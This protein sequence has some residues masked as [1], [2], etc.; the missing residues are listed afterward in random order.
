[1]NNGRYS[2]INH[3]KKVNTININ[4]NE[5]K[6]ILDEKNKKKYLEKINNNNNDK[7]LY[8]ERRTINPNDDIYKSEVYND[9]EN[10]NRIKEKVFNKDYIRKNNE[11]KK[12]TKNSNQLNKNVIIKNNNIN[13]S[14]NVNNFNKRILK[15]NMKGKTLNSNNIKKTNISTSYYI[16]GQ[17]NTTD[18]RYLPNNY[19]NYNERNNNNNKVIIKDKYK[20]I[21]NI[22]IKNR[23]IEDN[24]EKN[25]II[26]NNQLTNNS[27]YKINNI[28]HSKEKYI[29]DF[30]NNMQN[31]IGGYKK[32]KNKYRPINNNIQINNNINY[33]TIESNVNE[34]IYDYGDVKRKLNKQ[35]NEK[36]NINYIQNDNNNVV[37]IGMK[38]L[39]KYNFHKNNSSST[40][41]CS[42]NKIQLIDNKRTIDDKNFDDYNN[43]EKIKNKNNYVY[44][45]NRNISCIKSREPIKNLDSDYKNEKYNDNKNINKSINKNIN[46]KIEVS[47]D[48]PV[49]AYD[50]KNE[51]N[52]V[53]YLNSSKRINIQNKNKDKKNDNRIIEVNELFN[54]NNREKSKYTTIQNSEVEFN[55]KNLT[56]KNSDKKYY[57]Q[58]LQENNDIDNEENNYLNT[59]NFIIYNNSDKNKTYKIKN[60]QKNN[61]IYENNVNSFDRNKEINNSNIDDYKDN[62]T[63]YNYNKNN[64]I[65]SPSI[66]EFNNEKIKDIY[67]EEG[68]IMNF[69]SDYINNDNQRKTFNAFNNKINNYYNN[70]KKIKTIRT[71][72]I[73]TDSITRKKFSNSFNNNF[74]EVENDN[75]FNEK[76]YNKNNLDSQ[77]NCQKLILDRNL[78]LNYNFYDNSNN[79]FEQNINKK[80]NINNNINKNINSSLFIKKPNYTGKSSPKYI[81]NDI[82]NDEDAP[83]PLKLD[84]DI[85]NNYFYSNNKTIEDFYRDKNIY[86]K[87]NPKI[88]SIKDSIESTPKS[89]KLYPKKKSEN[90]FGINNSKLNN[91]FNNYLEFNKTCYLKKQIDK[92]IYQKKNLKNKLCDFSTTT[93]NKTIKKEQTDN[94]SINSSHNSNNNYKNINI[95]NNNIYLTKNNNISS[96]LLD[97][98][99]SIKLKYDVSYNLL[100]LKDKTNNKNHCFYSKL[101]NYHIKKPKIQLYYLDKCIKYN[102]KNKKENKKGT[103]NISI[104]ISNTSEN[105]N[106]DNNLFN[107]SFN[108]NKNNKI[109]KNKESEDNILNVKNINSDYESKD[110]SEENF[111]GSSIN[112]NKISNIKKI[113]ND[114]NFN[115]CI[116]FE[117][118]E[119]KEDK[120]DI[121]KKDKDN[122][123]IKRKINNFLESEEDEK[124][125]QIRT[126]Q[127]NLNNNKYELYNNYLSNSTSK[128]E[129]NIYEKDNIN[130]K[131]DISEKISLLTKKLSNIF[132]KKNS[133]D[134]D[135]ENNDLIKNENNYINENNRRKKMRKSLTKK[136]IILGYSKLNNIF[137]KKTN[138]NSINY[139]L[140]E[141]NSNI[142]NNNIEEFINYKIEE[143]INDTEFNEDIKMKQ[144][145]YT[146]KVKKKNKLLEDEEEN[147]NTKEEN[148]IKKYNLD[149]IIS[150]KKT[151][152]SKKDNLL[153]NKVKS[154]IYDLL[155]PE[156]KTYNLNN[157]NIN[158]NSNISI[159]SKEKQKEDK[160]INI[161]KI[162]N[163]LNE[164][165]LDYIAEKLYE[166]II[167]ENECPGDIIT[168][169]NIVLDK[170]TNDKNII[171]IYSQLC[172]KV[173]ILLLKNE[174][175]N[176][177][178]K[179]YLGKII[180]NEFLQR[181]KIEE[182][183]S[184]IRQKEY[185]S[186]KNKYL[187]IIDFIYN[188]IS[189]KII[190]I[191]EAIDIFSQIFNNYENIKEKIK[192]IY[193]EGSIYL[194]D[195]LVESI[196]KSSNIDNK[197]I[198]FENNIEDKLKN[199]LNDINIPKILKAKLIKTL[200]KIKENQKE[201]EITYKKDNNDKGLKNIEINDFTKEKKEKNITNKEIKLNNE[202]EKEKKEYNKL[203]ENLLKLEDKDNK[204][205]MKN[206]KKNNN[207]E[208]INIKN[209]NKEIKN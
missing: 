1:M 196:S 144:K 85:D 65:K 162:L 16:N 103:N 2:Q 59:N 204:N 123:L 178:E 50:K 41:Y 180:I 71:K 159:E 149:T 67:K 10:R 15:I 52:S 136:E 209:K 84:E 124:N 62:I 154:H 22:S 31:K 109:K 165:N 143:E 83:Y 107:I 47:F 130:K 121:N 174:L 197:K 188:I 105:K 138:N 18:L 194:L 198:I 135:D 184:Y 132:N 63:N 122:N 66:N 80:S 89:K 42:P 161:I 13:Q 169:I 29:T 32:L 21:D 64:F 57:Y 150:L 5:Q 153:N 181:A 56:V 100:D 192:Y 39:T 113:E 158:I 203:N 7:I 4:K 117:L 186:I 140:K 157:D 38:S 173:N 151:N 46:K 11:E 12:N 120:N 23:K 20:N 164:N 171:K 166:N 163:S 116:N 200:E 92:N 49:S 81:K 88:K 60:N 36:N 97:N 17:P 98:E 141:R 199:A 40:I 126:L 191:E 37:S 74:I 68:N 58:T 134:K 114:L 27:N 137:N 208:I 170:V 45:R 148:N 101:Y 93:E 35:I 168:F 79:D 110:N 201:H 8:K 131:D 152:L 14:S 96:S 53:S 55:S 133:Y 87:E 176:T 142:I 125:I 28:N 183:R 108:N 19:Y 156:I 72:K 115:D 172:E 155:N 128:K 34:D 177:K 61:I 145:V 95:S 25:I 127:I 139:S 76:N 54:R 193:L 202:R 112:K 69:N 160:K 82:T 182:K 24:K 91:E 94:Y 77:K 106:M 86:R 190:N 90:Y 207:E 118:S 3:I 187:N 51:R 179:K 75:N 129:N 147:K 73:I 119:E 9:R 206:N 205:N 102:K 104:N 99:D 195:N 189:T 26:I 167:L 43:C 44:I 6:R 185:E 146:Y 30:Q 48:S 111:F 175:N 70:S 33:K 78:K